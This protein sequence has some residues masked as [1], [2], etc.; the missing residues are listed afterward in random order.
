MAKK[1]KKYKWAHLICFILAILSC[2][3]PCIV[4]TVITAPR[5]VTT[6]DKLALGGV[7]VFFTAVIALVVCKSLVRKLIA[8]MPFTLVVLITLFAILMLLICLKK[9]ID[10]AIFMM[11]VGI[12]GAGVG[13][14]FELMA[15]YYDGQAEE[16]KLMY[17]RGIGDV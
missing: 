9:I 1:Y 14:I 5:M 2:V 8:K 11:F 4:V 15:T 16:A 13:F 17:Q 7:S 3:L 12:G 6:E 10:D